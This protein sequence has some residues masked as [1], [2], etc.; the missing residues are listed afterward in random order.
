MVAAQ[1]LPEAH[2]ECEHFLRHKTTLI[3]PDVLLANGV[4]C[5][6]LRQH[7][8]EFV[9]TFPRSYH[10]GFN[11]GVNTAESTNFASSR[12]LPAGRRARVC[13]CQPYS[14]RINMSTFATR[15]VKPR[16]RGFSGF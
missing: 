5:C 3:S 12:W 8:G 11:F 9:I 7:E 10:F 15:V 6:A 2:G 1:C 16:V 14:V 13:L 4:P